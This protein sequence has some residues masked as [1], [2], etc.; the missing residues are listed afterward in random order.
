MAYAHS[1]APYGYTVESERLVTAD[2]RT[3]EIRDRV[4]KNFVLGGLIPVHQED[5]NFSGTRCGDT[6]RD[7]RVEATCY[8]SIIL[9]AQKHLLF[10]IMLA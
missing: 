2:G 6:R 10:K 4:N 9:D 5:P 3:R 8:A 7:Q 1:S